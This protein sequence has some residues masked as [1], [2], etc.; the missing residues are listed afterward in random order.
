ESKEYDDL[1]AYENPFEASKSVLRAYEKSQMDTTM[2]GKPLAPKVDAPVEDFASKYDDL[3]KY[4]PVRWNEPDGLRKLTPEELSKNYEDL[5]L[6]DAV[7]WNEPDGLRPLT[8]EEKSKHY[9]D[10]HL[11][12]ARDLS[13][14]TSRVHPEEASKAYKDLPAYRHYDNAD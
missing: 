2:R 12:A 10:T 1:D 14:R 4:G 3:H 5:H 9:N 11:Y 7:R 6:Y 8:A 13:P